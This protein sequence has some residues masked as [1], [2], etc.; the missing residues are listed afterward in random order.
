MVIQIFQ[1][2]YARRKHSGI[3]FLAD[4]RKQF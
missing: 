3:E 2:E 4:L 1:F